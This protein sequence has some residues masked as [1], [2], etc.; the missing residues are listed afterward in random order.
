[1]RGGAAA[2]L[3]SQLRKQKQKHGTKPKQMGA[4][5]LV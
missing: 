4:I 2:V 1:M 3:Q 5:L